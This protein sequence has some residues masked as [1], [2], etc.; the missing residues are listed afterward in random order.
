MDLIP[1]RCLNQRKLRKHNTS[2]FVLIRGLIFAISCLFFIK[3]SLQEWLSGI[4]KREDSKVFCLNGNLLFIPSEADGLVVKPY[5][6]PEEWEIY[7]GSSLNEAANNQRIFFHETSG[8][9]ELSLRQCCAVESAAR[10]N[11]DRNIQLFLGSSDNCGDGINR[12]FRKIFSSQ[13]SSWLKVLSRYT[14]LSVVYL[15]EGYYFSGTPFQDWYRKGEW[16]KSPFKMGHLSDFIRILTLYKGGGMYMDL[17]IMTLKTFHGIMFNNYLVYENAK[18][19]TIGNSIMH[20]E[21]GHQ[22]TIEL[23]RLLSEE[24]DP[25]AYVYHGPDAIAEVM[26]RVC[27]LVAGNPNSNKC[28][29]VKLLP[30]RYFHPVAAMFSH[31]LFKNDI[32]G[33][34]QWNSISRNERIDIYSNQVFSVLA[35]EHCPLTLSGAVAGFPNTE[36]KIVVVACLAPNQSDRKYDG[37]TL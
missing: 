18:M 21:R 33:T 37:V 26:N 6:N 3:L 17:D 30:H 14:N 16:R 29:D 31:M 13:F 22:I 27:G 36:N 25:E 32:N 5:V 23:I 24:Y 10:H 4:N 12:P 8:R 7:N 20:F 2:L 34:N 19:D 1:A 11:P 15:N 35:R 9:S 28:G